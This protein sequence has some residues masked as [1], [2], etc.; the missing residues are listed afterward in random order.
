MYLLIS[1]AVQGSV[2]T[3]LERKIQL[4]TIRS[5]GMSEL[6]DGWMALNTSSQEEGD[7][8]ISCPLKTEFLV[9]LEQCTNGGVQ[10][11]IGPSIS[12]SKKKGKMAT[13]NFRKDDSIPRGDVYKSSTVSVPSG[14][15]PNS[16][17]APPV[18]RKSKPKKAPKQSANVRPFVAT[19]SRES[20]LTSGNPPTLQRPAGG[21]RPQA[22]T[23]PGANGRGAVPPAP[24]GIPHTPVAPTARKPAATPSSRAAPPPPSRAPAPPPPPPPAAAPAKE[25]FKA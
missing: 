5:V 8:L 10:V 12:Y 4:V 24:A 11:N 3:S 19:S 9:H 21:R 23:L 6:Q 7:P 1:Q 2:Q 22:Q 16:E 17:S 13:I 15:P 25:M 18:P 14:M 20:G